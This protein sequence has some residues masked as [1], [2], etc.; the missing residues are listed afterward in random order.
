[1]KIQHIKFC[2]MKQKQF[3]GK[4]HVVSTYIKKLERPKI[5]NL[6]LHFKE[7]ERGTN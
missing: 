6:I 5:N 7:L 1:M 2:G 4:F 3:W